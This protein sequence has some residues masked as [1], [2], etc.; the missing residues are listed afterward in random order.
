MSREFILD[1]NRIPEIE[2]SS[3]FYPSSGNDWK[4]PIKLFSPIITEFWFVDRGYF[5]P[6]HCDTCH[7]G[8][9][10]PADKQAPLLKK[11][12]DYMLIKTG[13][14]GPVSWKWQGGYIEPCILT[15]TYIHQSSK[16]QIRIHRRRGYGF[17]AF[18][19][20]IHEIGV[21][22]YRGDSGGDGGSGN[23]WLESGHLNEVCEK[24]L[25]GGLIVTDGSNHGRRMS[26]IRK[27]GELW[28]NRG[29]YGNESG[30]PEE[31]VGSMKTFRDPHGRT[32]TCIGYA[33]DRYGPTMIW[34]VR[35][36]LPR[37]SNPE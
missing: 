16:K 18:R 34:K 10:A 13:I 5:H 20:Q 31:L 3:L 6:G 22:F 21:F 32:F 11:D 9:D 17:S 2:N 7:Y 36:N 4:T 30:P 27:Y 14:R 1:M 19:K 26:E 12:S 37:Y 24:L 35:K 25:D 29:L 15:E 23:L 8:F 28:K 33:G